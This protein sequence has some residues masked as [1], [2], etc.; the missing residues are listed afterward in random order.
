MALVNIKGNECVLL[1]ARERG[2]QVNYHL[3]PHLQME[4]YTKCT[5]P[6]NN[7][8]NSQNSSLFTDF[9]WSAKIAFIVTRLEINHFQWIK[10]Y[11]YSQTSYINS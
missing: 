9:R 2:I 5:Y 3:L 7:L 10:I 6:V 11:R 8:K 1:L 4:I